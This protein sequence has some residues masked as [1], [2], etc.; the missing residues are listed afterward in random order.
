MALSSTPTTHN[1]ARVSTQQVRVIVVVVV[2]VVV[3]CASGERRRRGGKGGAGGG[4]TDRGVC[5][6]A[7]VGI[8]EPASFFFK[9]PKSL[10]GDGTTDGC[11]MG[12]RSCGCTGR[13]VHHQTQ[14]QLD[15]L[16]VKTGLYVIVESHRASR[17]HLR[18]GRGGAVLPSPVICKR[19]WGRVGPLFSWQKLSPG[20]GGDFAAPPVGHAAGSTTRVHSSG[21]LRCDSTFYRGGTARARVS[22]R[23][24]VACHPTTVAG[25]IVWSRHLVAPL[26][27]GALFF[28]F[29][30]W[31]NVSSPLPPA[32]TPRG[33]VSSGCVNTRMRLDFLSEGGCV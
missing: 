13:S 9:W 5:V 12:A 7:R 26:A 20:W 17:V 1:D 15:V 30:F 19:F 25:R 16:L 8:G 32:A 22:N 2:V 29:L 21:K 14:M 33:A 3:R 24:G 4:D 11:V 28:G 31:Q 6:R 27:N 23:I 18:R 10:G